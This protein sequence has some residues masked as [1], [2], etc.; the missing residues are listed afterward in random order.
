VTDNAVVTS[1]DN[2][3]ATPEGADV[4]NARLVAL[5]QVIEWSASMEHILRG[6]F[7]SLVGSKYAAILAGGQTADGLIE[8][9]KALTD[10]HYEMPAE[11]RDAIHAALNRCKLANQRRNTLVHG[12]K[13][14]SRVT[15]GALQTIRSRRRS[16][17]PTV[18]P[19]TPDT[20]REAATELLMAGMELFGAMEKAV[21]PQVMVI[22]NAL[23]WEERRR[24]EE[25]SAG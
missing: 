7:C 24:A 12:V 4:I 16:N 6:A 18:E 5:G 25:G 8:D 20:I 19:W 3:E 14:A 1:E 15:D 21:S 11:H 2:A 22:D 17:T 10:A 23:A 9:C 13:T